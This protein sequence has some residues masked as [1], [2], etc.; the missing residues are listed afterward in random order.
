MSKNVAAQPRVSIHDHYTPSMP[1][2]PSRVRLPSPPLPSPPLKGNLR[3]VT[4]DGPV[5][6]SK[7]AALVDMCTRAQQPYSGVSPYSPLNSS[8]LYVLSEYPQSDQVVYM[9]YDEFDTHRD[10]A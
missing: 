7:R 8:L 6:P 5:D 2:H 3:I 10:H 9:T 1:K 4:G